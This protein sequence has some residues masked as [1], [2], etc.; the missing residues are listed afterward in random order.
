MAKLFIED[1]DLKGKRALIR[2]DF[3]V[4]Q[5]KVTALSPIPSVLKLLFPPSSMHLKRVLP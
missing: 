2:V 5:D 3:N 1:L 4:P